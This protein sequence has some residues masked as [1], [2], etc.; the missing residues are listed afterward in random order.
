MSYLER[1]S[2]EGQ[3]RLLAIDGGG[4]RGV[5]AIEILGVLEERLREALGAPSDFVLADCFDYVAGT[6][7]G[8]I[9]ATCIAKGFGVAEMRVFFDDGARKLLV[10]API[11][12]RL[13]YQY[14]AEGL[15]SKLKADRAATRSAPR[16]CGAVALYCFGRYPNVKYARHINTRCRTPIAY[17]AGIR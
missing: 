5:I 11:W 15:T 3:K 6:S 9:I 7:T 8:A 13:K 14:L 10:R 1:I 2:P 4:I 17:D 12:D 16:A